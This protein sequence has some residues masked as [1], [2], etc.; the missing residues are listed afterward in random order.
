MSWLNTCQIHYWGD[1]A[2]H[3]FAMLSQLRGYFSKA[4]CLPNLNEQEQALYKNLK[5]NKYQLC[6]RLEQER[7]P[8]S[9][10][11]ALVALD[12]KNQQCQVTL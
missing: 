4:Q 1:I 6:L 9:L 12:G 10:L 5:Q 3:G 11:E 7:I 8:F 2:T